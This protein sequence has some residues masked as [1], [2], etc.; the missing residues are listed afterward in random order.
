[1]VAVGF[2]PRT[3]NTPKD[4]ASGHRAQHGRRRLRFQPSLRDERKSAGIANRGLKPTATI[5]ASLRDELPIRLRE[6]NQ[7]VQPA[8]KFPPPAHFCAT[9]DSDYRSKV[10]S[11][12]STISTI[13]ARQRP[14]YDLWHIPIGSISQSLRFRFRHYMPIFLEIGNGIQHLGNFNVRPKFVRLDLQSIGQFE[15]GLLLRPALAVQHLRNRRL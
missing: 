14:N 1:M 10:S 8:I 9:S 2:N 6:Q 13:S 5:I 15:N 4:I 12:P 3:T 11:S 7:A